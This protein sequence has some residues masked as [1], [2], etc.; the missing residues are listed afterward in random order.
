M[1]ARMRIA[2]APVIVGQGRKLFVDMDE[3]AKFD[4]VSEER[5][6]SG[7]VMCRLARAG[8]MTVAT[9]VRGETDVQAAAAA[10]R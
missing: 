4:L 5:T 2:I 8:A 3:T 7:L 9:Y 6:P 10:R 1:E